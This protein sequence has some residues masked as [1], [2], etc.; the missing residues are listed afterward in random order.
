MY[1]KTINPIT[2]KYVN[3][4]PTKPKISPRS[5]YGMSITRRMVANVKKTRYL[6][7][8]LLYALFLVLIIRTIVDAEITDSINHPVLNCST[9][10]FSTINNTA[11]VI[12][13]K[14]VLSNPK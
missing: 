14:N 1:T 2:S 11:K 3:G 10:A 8:L 13:S 9:D 7:G 6:L 4:T 12:K 5:V